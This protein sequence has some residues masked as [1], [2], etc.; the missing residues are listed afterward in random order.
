MAWAYACNGC[1]GARRAVPTYLSSLWEMGQNLHKVSPVGI[2]C[3]YPKH[4]SLNPA[5]LTHLCG[6]RLMI[7]PLPYPQV[8][9]FTPNCKMR[10]PDPPSL[11]WLLCP[12][13]PQG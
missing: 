1:L 4:F 2:V 13:E 7:C 3:F 8:L 9:V 6:F 10:K 12:Q 5:G 11:H